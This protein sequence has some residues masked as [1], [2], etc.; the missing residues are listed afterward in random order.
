MV[1]DPR[2]LPAEP[3][4]TPDAPLE[5]RWIVSRLNLTAGEMNKALKEYRF[6]EAANLVYSF[7]WGDLCDW[8]WK[9]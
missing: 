4:V 8:Y 6:H 5:T 2:T 3:S 7:F 9:W 1:V